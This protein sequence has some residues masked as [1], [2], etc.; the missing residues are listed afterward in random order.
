MNSNLAYSESYNIR[1]IERYIVMPSQATAYKVGMLK[2]QQLRAR[3]QNILGEKFDIREFHDVV[4][5]DGA[6]SMPIL[7]N[8]I[9]AW[10]N[11]LD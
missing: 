1:Q 3:A 6:V 5:K 4:L 10:V 7:E 11:S 8:N 9:N 2:I